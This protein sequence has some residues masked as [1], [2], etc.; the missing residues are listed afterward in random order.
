MA[1]A[2]EL[3]SHA[4]EV[5]PGSNR[6]FG[7]VFAAVFAVIGCLPLWV[8][9]MPRWWA[10]VIAAALGIVAFVRPDLL[11]PLNRVWF[12]I[13]MVLSRVVSPI[14]LGVVYF[15][16]VTPIGLI[17]RAMGKDVLAL[18]WRGENTSY[19]IVREPHQPAP[20]TM[21]NQF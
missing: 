4:A 19:W 2:S 5:R 11:A 13:G 3:T 20:E 14:V 17:M 8:G 6:S 1:T 12:R 9:H 16:C 7:L 18:R 10:V 21:K 15:L